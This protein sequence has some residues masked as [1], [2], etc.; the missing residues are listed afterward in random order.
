MKR[1][2]F[3][4]QRLL[5]VRSALVRQG[6]FELEIALARVRAERQELDL[7]RE[8]HALF[9]GRAVGDE[10]RGMPAADMA[11]ARLHL[12]RLSEEIEVRRQALSE[13]AERARQCQLRLERRRREERA[14]ERLAEHRKQAHAAAFAA[15]EQK[16]LDESATVRFSHRAGATP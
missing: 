9:A 3:S 8:H 7:A 2:R 12:D 16:L 13:A 1:F 6:R 4:L 5:D 15:E 11:A 14:L 10:V